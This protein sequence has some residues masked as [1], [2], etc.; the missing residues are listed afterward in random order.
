MDGVKPP[1]SKCDRSDVERHLYDGRVLCLSCWG[2]ATAELP[3]V[4]GGQE[5]EPAGTSTNGQPDATRKRTPASTMTKKRVRWLWRG[6]LALGYLAVWC[7]AGDIGKSMFAAWVIRQLTR[8]ELEGEHYGSPRDVLIVCTEDGRDD[9]WLPRLEAVGADLSRVYFLDYPLGWNVRDGVG[10]IEA[11]VGGPGE[12]PLAFVD[13][14]MSHM[15]EAKGGENTRSPTFVREALTPLA[16]VCKA[17]EL[18]ALFGLHPRKAGGDTFAD[19][20]QESG[21]FTQ[22]PRLGLLFG[23]HP[24]DFELPRDEQRRVV[25]RGKGNIGRNPGALSFRIAEKFLDYGEDDPNRIADGV[26]Y[27]NDVQPCDVTERQLLT[28]KQ[29]DPDRP[30][31][32]VERAAQIIDVA[33]L[34]GEWHDA[35][36]ICAKLAGF[37]LGHKG[38]VTAAKLRLGVETRKQA[39]MDGGWEW[40]IEQSFNSTP[41]PVP[42]AAGADASNSAPSPVPS[43]PGDCLSLVPSGEDRPNHQQ[44][45]ATRE[46]TGDGARN[47]RSASEAPKGQGTDSQRASTARTPEEIEWLIEQT[48]EEVRL[49]R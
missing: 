11:A 3:P 48:R 34:D 42:S 39:T 41:S 38:T 27:I 47:E 45:W 10:L 5:P 9:M 13:A 12:V 14:V 23:Y 32:K 28:V 26:G 44:S 22:L 36:P 20:V 8:G 7:G 18:T 29:S 35:G 15:P 30:P 2:N 49:G 6:R 40:R 21:A 16:D 31:S 4:A 25:L 43:T 33:L 1:C 46:G 37:E 17:K 24:E 19:V